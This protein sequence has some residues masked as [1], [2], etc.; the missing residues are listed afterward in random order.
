MLVN[1]TGNRLWVEK[2]KN[3]VFSRNSNIKS[4]W[5]RLAQTALGDKKKPLKS[6]RKTPA[7]ILEN[8]EYGR[9]AEHFLGEAPKT[10]ASRHYTHKNGE[11]FD[12]A[13]K[14]LGEQFG[15]K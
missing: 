4:S 7:T 2:E 14:W 6:L 13:I 9:F 8:S 15:I 10:I 3:G 5:F 11:E 1:K 12:A